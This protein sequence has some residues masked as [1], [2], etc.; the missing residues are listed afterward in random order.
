MCAF[1][2]SP[3]EEQPLLL[4]AVS[5]RDRQQLNTSSVTSE[6]Q[7]ETAVEWER[8]SGQLLEEL[9]GVHCAARSSS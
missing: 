1:N 8:K 3:V 9:I 7:E 2:L 4:T 5:I 6:L